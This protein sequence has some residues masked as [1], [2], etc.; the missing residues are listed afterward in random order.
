MAIREDYTGQTFGNRLVLRNYCVDEDWLK[1]GK[2]PPSN[3]AKYRL[4]KC[5]NCGAI[6][7]SDMR[8]F[9]TNPP[10]RCVFCSNIGN[11]Y[12]LD[13]NTNTWT[14]RGDVAI[15]NVIFKGEVIS[16][17]VDADR[18]ED[19]SKYTW[20]ISQKKNKYYVI[21]GSQ[22]KNTM[23]YLHQYIMGE[24]IDGMEIDHIDGNSL[25]N[26]RINLR[27]TTRQENIDNIQA[28]RI[29]NKIGIRGVCY[30]KKS[31]QWKIDF[32]YHGQRFYTKH[33]NTIE[34]AVYARYCFEK[35]FG[36]NLVE[37]NPLAR[38]YKLEDIN[39]RKEIEKYIL[40]KIS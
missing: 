35:Y 1:I 5:L 2:E 32:I 18:Y 8:D 25:N 21:T 23:I 37:N 3:K 12:N 34:E 29:D 26:R 30:N 27:Y 36:M 24:I 22:K 38:N 11:H 16:F 9:R 10:K 6:I 15:C 33:W 31:K 13:T 28:T 19:V 20:R 17:Y 40:S 39:K 14:V 7:P 4:T